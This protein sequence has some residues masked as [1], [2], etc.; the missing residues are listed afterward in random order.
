ME[1]IAG[2]GGPDPAWLSELSRE[3]NMKVTEHEFNT[4]VRS[5][6][7]ES[8]PLYQRG[9]AVSALGNLLKT[10]KHLRTK[11][12]DLSVMDTLIELIGRTR[13]AGDVDHGCSG[14]DIHKVRVNCCV[15]LSMVVESVAGPAGGGMMGEG[16]A[17]KKA[18]QGIIPMAAEPENPRK[19]DGAGA[20][21]NEPS[22][23]KSGERVRMHCPLAPPPPPP[24]P[25]TLSPPPPWP[26]L[27]AQAT[28]PRAHA[29]GEVEITRGGVM[30]TGT[31]VGDGTGVGRTKAR[32]GRQP[33]TRTLLTARAQG[34]GRGRRAAGDGRRSLRASQ[35]SSASTCQARTLVA[36]AET[37]SVAWWT[38]TRT[39]AAKEAPRLP[40]RCRPLSR[41]AHRCSGRRQGVPRHSTTYTRSARRALHRTLTIR[42]RMRRTAEAA[43]CK[44][45]G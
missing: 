21:G 43:R 42:S 6:V 10:Q 2:G 13:Q 35:E 36:T 24:P 29:S 11:V 5:I 22:S 12:G 33:R 4:V 19:R 20:S 26:P 28:S 14:A 30:G 45:T 27:D 3:K 9:L 40:R 15:V 31:G 7:D 16:A 37:A 38:R 39:P 41:S 44:A 8:Q 32:P 34:T 23:S 17:G 18:E 25:T 1:V